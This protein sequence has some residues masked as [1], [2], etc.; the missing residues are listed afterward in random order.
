VKVLYL[1]GSRSEIDVAIT[2]QLLAVAPDLVLTPVGRPAEALVEVRRT[3]GW[4][5]LFVSPTLAQNDA[6]AL[7]ASLRR[8]R[9]PIAI[10]PVVE[11]TQPERYA[12][13][14]SSGADDVLLRRGESLVNV[15]ETIERIRQGQRAF[16]AETRRRLRVL[17]AG[18]DPLVWASGPGTSWHGCAGSPSGSGAGCWSTTP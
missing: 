1:K 5:A 6:L 2:Q 13:T 9:V 15:A 12:A 11:E 18:R 3:P 16:P 17:Y 4:Q 14:V 10:V 8:D 7:I